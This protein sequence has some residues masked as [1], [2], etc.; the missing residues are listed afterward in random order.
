MLLTLEAH[1]RHCPQLE[2]RMTEDG[3]ANLGAHIEQSF[4]FHTLLLLRDAIHVCTWEAVQL[5]SALS[6]GLTG[7]SLDT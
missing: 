5:I 1:E 3:L 4:R 7:Y 6:S 2:C